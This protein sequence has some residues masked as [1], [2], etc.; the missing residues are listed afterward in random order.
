[1][2]F[3]QKKL[4]PFVLITAF[5]QGYDWLYMPMK[6]SI[7]GA[8]LKVRSDLHLARRIYHMLGAGTIA[9]LY[10]FMPRKEM[11]ILFVGFTLLCVCVDLF[12][13]KSKK[14]ND[15]LL[16]TFGSFVRKSEVNNLT[17]MTYL[18]IG[19]TAIAVIFPK[20][21]VTLS[22]LMLAVGDP[23]SSIF[24]IMYGKDVLVGKKTLQ[25]TIA[26]FIACALVSIVYFSGTGLMSE[27]LI[28][29]SLV[30]GLIGA[31]SELTPV[32]G[33]DDNFTFPILSACLL[34]AQFS[35]M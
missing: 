23:I 12:R 27:R 34:W 17:G 10:Y 29:A 20:E 6:T 11:L 19:V 7:E 9:A 28:L 30:A 1:M 13:L 16:A 14:L 26:G 2:S 22:L 24:G 35:I 3:I 4:A 25:G 31:I 15:K 32:F 5:Y 33:L 8:T 18:T 21:I